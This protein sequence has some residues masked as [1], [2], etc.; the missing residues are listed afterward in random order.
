MLAQCYRNCF[1]LAIQHALCTIAFPGIST[2]AYRFP[3]ERATRIAVAETRS[4]LREA[5]AIEKV[6]FVCFS[7]D[8]YETYQR[9]LKDAE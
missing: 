7:Q 4:A 6:V 2:G 9:A 3:L 8:A 5:Q 1:A